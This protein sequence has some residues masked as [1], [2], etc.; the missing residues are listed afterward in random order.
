MTRRAVRVTALILPP[1]GADAERAVA[2]L[3]EW[4]DEVVLLDGTSAGE[5]ALRKSIGAAP[6][7]LAVVLSTSGPGELPDLVRALLRGA[8][9]N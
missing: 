9:A 1:P 5:A 4:V 6:E 3:L 7:G 8:A 2:R